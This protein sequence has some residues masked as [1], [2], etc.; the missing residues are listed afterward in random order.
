M[1][2]QR[3]E[4]L[5]PGFVLH[6]RPFRETSRILELAT[7]DAGRVAVLARGR[8]GSLRPFVLLD[9]AWRGRGEL[10]SLTTGEEHRAYPLSGRRMICALYLNELV[11]KLIPRDARVG[12]LVTILERAYNGLLSDGRP[13]DTLR[14]AEWSLLSLLD[15]GLEHLGDGDFS[16]E[17]AYCYRPESGL[18]EALGEQTPGAVS[19]AVLR[20]LATGS[21][22]PDNA[23]RAARDFMRRL[24]DDHLEGREVLTRRLL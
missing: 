22:L 10:P 6:A 13:E 4:T 23:H 14:A 15:T 24:I 21:G 18:S 12:E 2:A 7:R 1:T 11:L 8:G 17:S 19:G 16:E 20:A 5:T 3:P 9:L